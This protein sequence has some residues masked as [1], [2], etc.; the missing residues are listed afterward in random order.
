MATFV[1]D[2]DLK[3][4][5]GDNTSQPEANRKLRDLLRDALSD[6]QGLLQGVAPEGVTAPT[7][8]EIQAMSTAQLKPWAQRWLRRSMWSHAN[9][10]RVKSAEAT[11]VAPVRDAVDETEDIAA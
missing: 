4:R 2:T 6:A 8:A 1:A 3:L 7:V 5:V 10:Y 9:A 11:H